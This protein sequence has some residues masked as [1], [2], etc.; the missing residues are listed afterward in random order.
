MNI[1]IP[2]PTYLFNKFYN[3]YQTNKNYT[4]KNYQQTILQVI[5]GLETK[6][7][8]SIILLATEQIFVSRYR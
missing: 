8:R 7:G 1:R 5:I 3:I 6:F 2:T 4:Y